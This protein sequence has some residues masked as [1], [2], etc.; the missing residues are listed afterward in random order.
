MNR[1]PSIGSLGAPTI[2][3]PGAPDPQK[4]HNLDQRKGSGLYTE[5]TN[6]PIFTVLTTE[7]DVLTIEH[8]VRTQH[9]RSIYRLHVIYLGMK[10]A[11]SSIV[12]ATQNIIMSALHK[13]Y[14]CKS[15][16][17]RHNHQ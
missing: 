13:Q 2:L 5:S 14:N 3:T 12:Q 16:E 11:L 8:K 17:Y 9:Q 15:N 1:K 4:L 10:S 7:N 6:K